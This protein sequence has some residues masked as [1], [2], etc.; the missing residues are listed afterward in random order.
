LS[1][2]QTPQLVVPSFLTQTPTVE[3]VPEHLSPV[4]QVFVFPPPQTSHSLAAVTMEVTGVT[5]A[6]GAGA[7]PVL[8]L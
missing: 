3:A 4:A 1:I 8:K 6:T 7:A 2:V 5:G